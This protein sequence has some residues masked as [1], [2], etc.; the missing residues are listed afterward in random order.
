MRATG[1]SMPSAVRQL[2][3]KLVDGSDSTVA[4]IRSGQSEAC[5]QGGGDCGP[6]CASVHRDV[7]ESETRTSQRQA[8][9]QSG[10]LFDCSGS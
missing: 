8:A 4:T 3:V 1:A 10:M 7:H 5:C 2:T 6:S 9:S